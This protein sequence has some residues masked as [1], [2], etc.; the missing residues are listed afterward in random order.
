M[1]RTCRIATYLFF[2]AVSLAA[3]VARSHAQGDGQ[4]TFPSSKEAL[5]AFIAAVRDGDPGE[6]GAILGPGSE[7]VVSSS[8]SVADKADREKFLKWYDEGHSFVPAHN[9]ELTLQVG[10]DNWPLPIPLAHKADQWYWDGQAGKEEILY[11]RIGHNELAAINVCK[12]IVS[13]QRD[14]AA[15]AHD[16]KPAGAYAVRLVSQPGTQNGLY[17]EAK[18]GEP[19]S[20]AGPMLAQAANEGYDTSGNRTPYH[21]YYYRMLPAANGFGFVAYPADYRSGGVMTFLV[22]Q[23]G[24]IY[25]KDLGDK[26]ADIAQKMSSYGPDKTWTLVR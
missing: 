18:E 15:S 24:L 9:G 12:G 25:Q 17:W 5:T 2:S 13:A 21:G 10:K 22:S 14:Y 20:P 26:T 1:K 6:L 16:G 3:F 7:Q 23:K 19:E 8:D 11:R 4:K